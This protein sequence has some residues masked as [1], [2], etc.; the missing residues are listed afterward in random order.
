VKQENARPDWMVQL[1]EQKDIK[2]LLADPLK[3]KSRGFSQN[4]RVQSRQGISSASGQDSR[5]WTETPKEKAAR[6]QQEAEGKVDPV[7]GMT[8]SSLSEQLEHAREAK[9]AAEIEET[10][11]KGDPSRA[12]SLLELHQEKRRKDHT[13]TKRSRED[14]ERRSSSSKSRHERRDSDEERK[15]HHHSHRDHHRSRHTSSRDGDKKEHSSSHKRRER[16]RRKG[17]D[18]DD[19]SDDSRR[20]GKHRKRREDR[21]TEHRKGDKAAREAQAASKVGA[22]DWEAAMGAGGKMLDETAKKKA[23][24]DAAG[25]GDRFGRGSSSYL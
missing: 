22:W 20:A 6:L 10:I 16:D 17:K 2:A 19:S 14:S 9:R 4:T 1:P 24:R 8:A 23:I 21:D 25:L 11:R 13:S 12:T 3:L 18:R 7:G 5:L 15:R